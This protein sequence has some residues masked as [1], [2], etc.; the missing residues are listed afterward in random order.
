MQA[1]QPALREPGGHGGGCLPPPTA[2]MAR[3]TN[4]YPMPLVSPVKR[5]GED[6]PEALSGDCGDV[7]RYEVMGRPPSN[8]G[9]CFEER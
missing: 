9:G 1:I 3:T 8:R 2:L 4:V 6:A 5:I 7:T